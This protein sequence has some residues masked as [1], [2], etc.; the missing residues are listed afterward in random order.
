MTAS[1]R[2]R[3]RRLWLNIH[4]WI[5]VG[6]CLLAVPVSLTGSVLVWHDT[7]EEML[8]PQ[9][10]AVTGDTL[11]VPLS[12]LVETA[13]DILT[14]ATV[15]Q[16]R[17]PTQAGQ[18]A[19]VVARPAKAASPRETV[20]VWI[21]PPTGKVLDIGPTNNAFMRLM[22]DFHGNLL[23]PQW[24]GRQIVGWVGVG[25]LILSL[26]GIYLWWPRRQSF[27]RA[28]GWRTGMRTTANL[29]HLAGFWISIPLAILSLTG[30][31]ISFPQT[32]RAALGSLAPC[33]PRRRAR[34]GCKAPRPPWASR[35]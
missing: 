20:S 25:M 23:V 30:M 6:L 35:G 21:D 33:R 7:I 19:S 14:G 31:Y 32:A 18:P 16:I 15:T 5:G 26:S 24:S 29:H 27:I 4:L 9:R 10:Y 1:P 17:L 13:Q 22:H 8:E 28:L 12:T 2:G 34:R 3:L 11:G